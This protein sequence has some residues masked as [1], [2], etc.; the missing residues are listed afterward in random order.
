[1]DSFFLSSGARKQQ[2]GVVTQNA[3]EVLAEEGKKDKILAQIEYYFSVENLVKDVY[4]RKQMDDNGFVPLKLFTKF[5]RVSRLTTD[6]RTIREVSSNLKKVQ[7]N[8][9]LFHLSLSPSLSLRIQIGSGIKSILG[10]S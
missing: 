9:P 5:N 1:M 3:F 2:D 10:S 8:L 4:F 7:C 6:V